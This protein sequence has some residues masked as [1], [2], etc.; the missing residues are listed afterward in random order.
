MI[1]WQNFS[2]E[3]SREQFNDLIHS[4]V[5]RSLLTC[6]RTLKD[7]NVESEEVQAVVMVGGSTRVPYV[8]EKVGEFLVKH[9]SPPLI[10]TKLWHLVLQFKRIF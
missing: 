6:R 7:A 5:K 1:S 2:V 10:Q 4:L 9:H 8:R 3:I